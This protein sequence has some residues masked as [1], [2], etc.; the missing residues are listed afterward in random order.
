M[1]QTF[2]FVLLGIC[3]IVIADAILG[4]FDVWI[5]SVVW[6]F[7]LL[8]VMAPFS[9]MYWPHK[10]KMLTMK[11]RIDLVDERCHNMWQ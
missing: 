6:A 2:P 9:A 5:N 1:L 11:K 4:K 7:M 3:Y 10:L 8:P